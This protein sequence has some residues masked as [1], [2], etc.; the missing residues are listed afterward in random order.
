MLIAAQAIKRWNLVDRV[1]TRYFPPCEDD[2]LKFVSP[3]ERIWEEMGAGI[4]LP[5]LCLISSGRGASRFPRPPYS[6]L[7]P[8]ERGFFR[9]L[10]RVGR[11]VSG[12]RPVMR[13]CLQRF[14]P[15]ILHPQGATEHQVKFAT[16]LSRL[17][18]RPTCLSSQRRAVV[19]G[20]DCCIAKN[21]DAMVAR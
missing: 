13:L 8:T 10:A 7:F 11:P 12:I 4:R 21:F 14:A 20:L 5:G 17:Q 18:K 16:K 1:S 6:L 9:F 3:M 19:F 2:L 15:I